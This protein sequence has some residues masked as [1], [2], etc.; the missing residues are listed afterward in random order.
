MEKKEAIYRR[1]F[2][3]HGFRDTVGLKAAFLRGWSRN[4]LHQSHQESCKDAAD[5]LPRR[6]Y[7]VRISGDEA[8]KG[9]FLT[10]P[11]EALMCIVKHT[12][13]HHPR[14]SRWQVSMP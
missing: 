10:R 8:G 14:K 13:G 6:T 11:L 7:H 5:S 12:E 3:G 2:Y 4:H 9:V 1:S